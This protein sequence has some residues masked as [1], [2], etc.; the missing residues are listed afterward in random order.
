M[1]KRKKSAALR[2]ARRARAK[3]AAVARTVGAFGK[4]MTLGVASGEGR[5]G[6][7]VL[8]ENIALPQN[9]SAEWRA[10]EALCIELSW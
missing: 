1:T 9:R 8:C 6:L 2:R 5:S 10:Q 4:R 3:H 7:A